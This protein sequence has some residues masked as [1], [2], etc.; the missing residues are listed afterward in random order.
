MIQPLTKTKPDIRELTL[1]NGIRY[2]SDQELLML[3]LNMG[4]PA[5]PVET[6]AQDAL[7]IIDN[8]PEERILRELQ[9]IKGIGQAK[10]L[11]IAAAIELGRRRN[12]FRGCRISSP[13]DI[14]P[15]VKHYALKQTEH[16]ITATINGA[17]ELIEIRVVSIGTTNRTLVH[18]REIFAEPVAEHAAGIICCHNHPTGV[19]QPSIADRESTRILQDAAHILGINFLDHIILTRS[20][21]FSF[22]E[23]GLL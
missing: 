1:K 22:L 14:L 17:Q 3:I 2:P 4:S 19:C 11:S 12:D 23:H 9:A 8:F 7:K 15:F 5:I 21:F 6:I 18:P 16:F 20:D 13:A 10:A